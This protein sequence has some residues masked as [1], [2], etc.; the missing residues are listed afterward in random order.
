MR[1]LILEN[2]ELECPHELPIDLVKRI[3]PIVDKK[4][5]PHLDV[6]YYDDEFCINSAIFCDS[7]SVINKEEKNYGAD[8]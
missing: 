8:N 3:I 2:H 7:V 1:Y 5:N 6:E 4:G